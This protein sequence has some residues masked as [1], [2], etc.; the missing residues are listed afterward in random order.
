MRKIVLSLLLVAGLGLSGCSKMRDELG[1]SRHSPDEFTVVKRAPLTLPPD[2]NLRP[3][4]DG[5]AI[6]AGRKS[7]SADA[8]T[9]IFGGDERNTQ[10]QNSG[11]EVF[12]SKIGAQ[13]SD[14]SIRTV[15]DREN[16]YVALDNRSTIEKILRREPDSSNSVV[17]AKAEAARL[18]KNAATDRPLTEGETPVAD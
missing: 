1:L 15:L 17:D 2:Y 16:G 6:G 18:Q 3:P 5:S 13:E 10:D 4:A 7:A 12:L 9:A 8:R 14:S 11:N